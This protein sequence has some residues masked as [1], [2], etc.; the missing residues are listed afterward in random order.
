M[1]AARRQRQR[2]GQW[3]ALSAFCSERDLLFNL[4]DVLKIEP[5]LFASTPRFAGHSMATVGEAL[6]AAVALAETKFAPHSR[7]N[8]AHEP[9]FN[10]ESKTITMN[11]QVKTALTAFYEAGFGAA[12]ADE[13]LGGMQLPQTVCHAL[14][15][16]LYAANVGSITFPF[17]TVAA[18]NMLRAIGTP[19]QHRKYLVPML[20]GRFTGTMNLSETQAGSSLGDI[21]C[22]AFP[23][24]DG[25][26]DIVGNKMWISGG[27]HE[28]AENIVHMVLAKVADPKHPERTPPG[29][30]GISLFI[31]PK[32][33]VD[34]DGNVQGLNDVALGGLN[35]KMG[36]RG[37]TNCVM[38]YGE[39]GGCVG[40][41]LGEEGRGLQG[42]F[43]MMNEA[44]ITIGLIATALGYAGYAASL[45][46]ARDRR[47][48]RPLDGKDPKAPQ[49]AIVEHPDVK[50]ML[51]FQKAAVEASLSLCLFA[52]WLVDRTH[53]QQQPGASAQ[54]DDEA[55][56][57]DVLT[58]VVKSWPSEWCL[59]ANKW[60]IQVHGGYGYTRD[61]AVEQHYRDNRLN[62]IHEHV[63]LVR[64]L[65]R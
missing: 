27:E 59:E 5:T 22:K 62:M 14:M 21:T 6:S 38:H 63:C 10:P 30:K 55:L 61:F 16:P 17:L 12:H 56:L 31:V 2:A 43:K 34:A 25:R 51:L 7:L 39:N 11:P 19:E 58:P 28:L 13:E 35:H 37:A 33:R 53:H 36:W 23:R 24:P 8:D 47:Q 57:L 65:A 1:A 18:G 45:Q 40:E 52:S 60:A 48:G 46:Y 26:F 50:R 44:R 15:F 49:V 4:R 9:H 41:L 32:R 3:R 42:M 64:L 29:V 20:Q 54:R